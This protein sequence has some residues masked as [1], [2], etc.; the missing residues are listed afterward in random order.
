MQRF[1]FLGSNEA[2]VKLS[3]QG[4]DVGT[5][6]SRKGQGKVI[7]SNDRSNHEEIADHHGAAE[8]DKETTE[9]R[10]FFNRK[11]ETDYK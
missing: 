4:E 11:N 1:L 7:V 5:N 10:K 2:S 3:E 9:E 8:G 6:Y